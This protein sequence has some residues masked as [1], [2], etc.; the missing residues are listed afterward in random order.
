LDHV[1]SISSGMTH[2]KSQPICGKRQFSEPDMEQRHYGPR[3]L[4]D[5][6]NAGM[7]SRTACTR[8]RPRPVVFEVKAWP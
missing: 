1:D 5:S 7:G 6:D 2:Q 4:R 8:Q 3:W